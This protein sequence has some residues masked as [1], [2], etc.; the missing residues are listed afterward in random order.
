LEINLKNQLGHIFNSAEPQLQQ[1]LKKHIKKGDVVFDIGANMGYVSIVMSKLVGKKGKV[2]SFEAIPETTERCNRNIQLNGCKNIQLI[3]KALS[4]S[5]GKVTFRIPNG[6]DTHPMASMVWHKN[7]D[8]AISV[9]VETMTIDGNEKF[10]NISP[11]FLKIDVEGAEAKVIK[12]MEQLI[13]RDKPSIFI[14]CS[15]AGR[16]D[17]WNI[18]KE[19]K[20]SCYLASNLA[21]EITDFEEYFHDDFLWK[22]N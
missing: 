9:E 2:Y 13:K 19:L 22:V 12:G 15:K 20:Y 16:E 14:E 18:L 17:V 7:I 5:I 6:G 21:E 8:D 3:R 1:I 10:E 4:D 11:S